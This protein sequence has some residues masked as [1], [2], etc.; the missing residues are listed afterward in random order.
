MEWLMNYWGINPA[1]DSLALSYD[2]PFKHNKD[3][4]G[5]IYLNTG[6]II[7]QNNEQNKKAFDVL[8]SWDDCTNPEGKH[9]ECLDF[10]WPSG[11]GRPTDQGGFGTYIRY[12]YPDNIRGLPCAEANGFPEDPSPCKGSFIRHM[13]SGKD[14]LLKIYTG[15]QFP[16][17]FLE[18]LHKRFLSEKEN[19][20]WTKRD[21]MAE[22]W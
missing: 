19:F 3:K 18:S 2:P 8:T 14:T 6:F 13:W 21:L 7:H 9:P 4:F 10:A 17:K 16:G 22:E 20:Y 12:D 15:H 5:N 1:N 11:F